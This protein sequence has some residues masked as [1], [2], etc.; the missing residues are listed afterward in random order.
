VFQTSVTW[1]NRHDSCEREKPPKL[2]RSLHH[3]LAISC[4]TRFLLDWPLQ[5]WSLLLV[6]C[7]SSRLLSEHILVHSPSH[8]LKQNLPITLYD[9]AQPDTSEIRRV[10]QVFDQSSNVPVRQAVGMLEGITKQISKAPAAYDLL[11]DTGTPKKPLSPPRLCVVRPLNR[12]LHAGNS[13]SA[14]EGCVRSYCSSCRSCLNVQQWQHYRQLCQKTGSWLHPTSL[15]ARPARSALFKSYC[16]EHA[17]GGGGS[18]RAATRF[19]TQHTNPSGSSN[20]VSRLGAKAHALR[21]CVQA[22][23]HNS[24]C[25]DDAMHQ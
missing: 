11:G 18:R 6:C 17:P 13:S 4:E 19:I 14:A 8:R 24:K 22:V 5:C 21:I 15:A 25:T 9:M 23:S 16:A 1:A 10:L 12:V 2:A 20:A 3:T 7:Y